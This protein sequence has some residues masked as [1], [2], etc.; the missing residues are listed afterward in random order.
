MIPDGQSNLFSRVD[1]EDIA[2][3]SFCD[4][5]RDLL[6]TNLAAIDQLW[7]FFGEQERH[8]SKAIVLHMPAS[9]LG[10]VSIDKMLAGLP[11]DGQVGGPASL[12]E[13]DFARGMNAMQHFIKAVRRTE[14]SVVAALE[15]CMVLPL[16]G[17]PLACDFRMV[18]A[19]FILVNRMA[20]YG[21]APLGG[22][23]WFLARNVGR[24][25][26]CDLVRRTTGVD[27][28][29]AVKLGLVDE[30]VPQNELLAA[31]VAL[32]QD[33]ARRP[34]R[35]RLA[36]K[37]AAL[38]ADDSLEAY[39]YREEML[40][41]KSLAKRTFSNGGQGRAHNMAADIRISRSSIQG[42]SP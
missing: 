42:S 28:K 40:F 22:L 5:A 19:D 25:L 31:A 34:Y 15:G 16:F 26:A 41:K 23:P 14:L 2:I 29:G 4:R 18:S 32:A 1:K 9:A 24:K 38:A 6:G 7:R 27:A 36:L 11:F 17:P 35:N 33:F 30:V 13:T 39:L 37:Q 12:N 20:D 3:L 10:P 8:P 21:I